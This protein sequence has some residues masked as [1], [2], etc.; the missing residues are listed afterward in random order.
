MCHYNVSIE[1]TS[2]WG[3][4]GVWGVL[5]GYMKSPPFDVIWQE[6]MDENQVF[7]HPPVCHYNDSTEI[8]SKWGDWGVWDGYMEKLSL[9]G[10]MVKL[11]LSTHLFKD[12]FLG[13]C[14]VSYET[15]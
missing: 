8:T 11:F 4:W 7:L 10:A 3:D 1:I 15:S 13:H 14:S 2:K 9:E 6:I 5:G 12:S